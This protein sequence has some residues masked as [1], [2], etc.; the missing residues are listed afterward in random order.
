MEAFVLI[1]SFC[2]TISG[3]EKCAAYIIQQFY[4]TEARCRLDIEEAKLA[5][6]LEAEKYNATV[7]YL[8]G[9]CRQVK[10]AKT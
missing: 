9:E 6:V 5:N 4:P 2:A 10:W 7:F 1:V 3:E 8:E